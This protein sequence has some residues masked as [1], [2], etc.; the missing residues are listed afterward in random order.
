MMK[1]FGRK[2]IIEASPNTALNSI[3]EK[4]LEQ[5]VAPGFGKIR[6]NYSNMEEEDLYWLLEEKD[7]NGEELTR[8]EKEFMEYY[9]WTAVSSTF[10]HEHMHGRS[11]AIEQLR[12]YE[13][14][15][16]PD[17]FGNPF[18]ELINFTLSHFKNIY[19]EK[20]AETAHY[21]SIL[22]PLMHLYIYRQ[23]SNEQIS[24]QHFR[25][26]DDQ[27]AYDE[28]ISFCILLFSSAYPEKETRDKVINYHFKYL[29]NDLIQL[30]ENENLKI[31]NTLPNHRT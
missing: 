23:I 21:L 17:E 2:P 10:Y 6:E 4:Q 29:H 12:K 14:S 30:I 1:L 5:Q 26:I 15:I 7:N 18:K 16:L 25:K 28:F 20:P 22:F 3:P 27:K 31:N 11:M 9:G 19:E 24:I 8:E 13:Y